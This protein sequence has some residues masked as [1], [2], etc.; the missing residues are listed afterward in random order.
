MKIIA[1]CK[2][3]RGHEF[4]A[5]SLKSVY[6]FVDKFIYCHAALSWSGRPGNTVQEIVSDPALDPEKK[7]IH[8]KARNKHQDTQYEQL[9]EEADKHPHDFKMLIDTDEVWDKDE[10]YTC[11]EHLA[12]DGEAEAFTTRMYTHLKSPLFQTM[13]YDKLAPV[14]FLKN[15]VEF[16]G[17][18]ANEVKKKKLIPAHFHHLCYVRNSLGE[19]IEKI[20]NSCA[21]ESVPYVNI[22]EWIK[23]KWVPCPRG[24]NFLPVRNWEDNMKEMYQAEASDLPGELQDHPITLSWER[25]LGIE[26]PVIEEPEAVDEQLA[27]QVES[28]SQL[29]KEQ[30]EPVKVD[31]KTYVK[32]PRLDWEPR[33]EQQATPLQ[34]EQAHNSEILLVAGYIQE[35]LQDKTYD[36]DLKPIPRIFTKMIEEGEV[37]HPG[38]APTTRIFRAIKERDYQNY[39]LEEFKT[40][41][42]DGKMRHYEVEIKFR[43]STEPQ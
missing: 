23:Q 10:L 8:L 30:G 19:V 17:C 25:Y 34:P 26:R 37:L 9:V 11:L 41:V 3:W 31:G 43:V 15:G 32:D 22:K 1:L 40:A 5:A 18:R 16:K 27:A 21:T 2:T 6:K 29:T 35:M 12:K 13:D 14:V 20:M 36:K 24:T 39:Q 28:I 7:I 42:P 4:A 38:Q 33:Q